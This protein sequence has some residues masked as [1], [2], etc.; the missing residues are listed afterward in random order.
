M[1]M[2]IVYKFSERAIIQA[3]IFN[4][5]LRFFTFSIQIHVVNFDPGANLTRTYEEKKIHIEHLDDER[6]LL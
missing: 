4:E 3:L 5:Q 6:I 2:T 1:K